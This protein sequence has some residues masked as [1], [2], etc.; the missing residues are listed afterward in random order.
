MKYRPYQLDGDP[1]IQALRAEG[2]ADPDVVGVVLTGSRALGMVTDESDYDAAFIVTDAAMA[3]Y[4]Q[5]R[6]PVRG[7]TLP[8]PTTHADLWHEA[9]SSLRPDHLPAWA[10]QMW[11]DARVIYDRTGETT[12]AIDALRRIPEAQ[13]AETIA[14]L[15][16]AYL[17]G[18][19]RSLKSWRRGDDLGGRLGAADSVELLLG[20]LFALERHWRPFSSRLWL[21]L[22]RLDGQ[23][24]Q[25]GEVRDILLDL[26]A[27]GDP[28][29]QQAVAR[30]VEAL[31]RT[32]DYGG[33][34]DDWEGEIDQVLA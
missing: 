11:S 34:Y 20:L 3:R 13:A 23:G 6:H 8:P 21:H 16:D 31:L 19:Y 18:L 4:E 17:N 7:H 33:V 12:A 24:W 25:P 5:T 32:R 27:T 10:F 15:Y 14:G 22:E 28:R 30:Q 1:V 2:E 9:V 26:L 29:R